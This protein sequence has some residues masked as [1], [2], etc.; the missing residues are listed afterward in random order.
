MEMEAAGV[1]GWGD[2]TCNWGAAVQTCCFPGWKRNHR[3]SCHGMG[4]MGGCSFG[5]WTLSSICPCLLVSFQL[6]VTG[7][8]ESWEHPHRWSNHPPYTHK[9]FPESPD[10]AEDSQN[11]PKQS[12]FWGGCGFGCSKP[13]SSSW[14]ELWPFSSSCDSDL[15]QHVTCCKVL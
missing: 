2:T 1:A 10:Q 11:S 12:H 6:W 4:G 13:I 7:H 15:C 14:S 3:N 8:A 5:G 9:S